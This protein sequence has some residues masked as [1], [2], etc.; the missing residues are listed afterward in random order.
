MIHRIKSKIL[1]IN[2]LTKSTKQIFLVTKD[3]DFKSGQ[4][5]LLELVLE[6]QIQRRAYSI[7]SSPNLKN[8]IELCI[9]FSKESPYLS[10]LN[11][12]KKSQEISFMGP[13][14]K[15]YIEKTPKKDLA[16]ISAGTGIA[17]LKSMIENLLENKNFNKNIMLIHGYRYKKDILYKKL[18]SKLEKKFP[19]FKQKIILSKPRI[20]TKKTLKGHVQDFIG[21]IIQN[22][23][24]NDY[25][26]CGMKEMVTGVTKKLES[27]NV[28]EKQ[29]H[30]EKYN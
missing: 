26:I 9:K 11:K 20:K 13:A 1:K 14:G 23:K 7:A 8:K 22:P 24:K 19:N 4:Y 28:K 10:E 21:E 27:L 25:Y 29:I 2:N 18:F 5:I 30:F 15:F 16:F 12:M 6:N 3:F 17:P